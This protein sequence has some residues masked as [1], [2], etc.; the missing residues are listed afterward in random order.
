MH[1][2]IRSH[3]ASEIISHRHQRAAEARLARLAVGQRRTA[4]TVRSR[5]R[6]LRSRLRLSAV[7]PGRS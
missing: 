2:T 1:P 7:I 5:Q 4:G 3:L 6:D